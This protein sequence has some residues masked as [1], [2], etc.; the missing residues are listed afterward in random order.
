MTM[1]RFSKGLILGVALASAC[2]LSLRAVAQNEIQRRDI[3]RHCIFF[4]K[5]HF[6]LNNS[7]GRYERNVDYDVK[8][9]DFFDE[10]ADLRSKVLEKL[11]GGDPSFTGGTQACN[12]PSNRNRIRIRSVEFAADCTDDWIERQP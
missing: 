12:N 5:I 7:F 4:D 2:T 10:V 6:T 11:C 9:L 3:D 8:V 1:A